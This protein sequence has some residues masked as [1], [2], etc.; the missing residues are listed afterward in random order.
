[1]T[2]ILFN[3]S[4]DEIVRGYGNGYHDYLVNYDNGSRL[5]HNSGMENYLEQ[6][7]KVVDVSNRN[8]KYKKL[9]HK[10]GMVIKVSNGEVGVCFDNYSNAA[11]KYGLF[12]FE[13]TEIKL[14]EI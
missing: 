11:S 8:R 12:W 13:P 5:L 4:T 6:K 2:S 3:E 10:E 14:L 7:V 9:L 1:M